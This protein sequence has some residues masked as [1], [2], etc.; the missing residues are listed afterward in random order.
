MPALCETVI[1][2]ELLVSPNKRE[3]SCILGI[4]VRKTY[5]ES[6]VLEFGANRLAI[7]QA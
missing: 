2:I 4:P 3:T 7:F 1:V 6:N 5:S